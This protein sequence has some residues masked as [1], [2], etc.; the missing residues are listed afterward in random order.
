MTRD[1]INFGWL[2]ETT[3]WIGAEFEIRPNG[4]IHDAIAEVASSG[5][6]A[7]SWCYPPIIDGPPERAAEIY[8]LPATHQL[9]LNDELDGNARRSTLLLKVLSLLKGM[10]LVPV[11]W[12]H[13][14]R[15]PAK[16]QEVVGFFVQPEA[17][18]RILTLAAEFWR[19]KPSVRQLMIG[20]LHWHL[21]GRSYEQP[22]EIFN[23]Q[24]A[25]L[26]TCWLI[27]AKL[28]GLDPFG[29]GHASRILRLCDAYGLPVPAW[30]KISEKVSTLSTLRNELLHTATWVGEPIGFA[31][32]VEYPG[33]HLDL[34]KFNAHL[35]LSLLGEKNAYLQA[36]L[37]RMMGMIR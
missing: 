33:I 34:F 4:N 26:D 2:P 32:P 14:A 37:R 30:A 5:R 12:V 18:V 11:P 24:Y 19:D 10:H 8:N 29:C 23:A 17:V 27:H 13:F 9:L 15:V 3:T 20:A 28:N 21:Y 16:P 36:P 7:G 35:L 22:F 25:V 6:I 1:V 31:H